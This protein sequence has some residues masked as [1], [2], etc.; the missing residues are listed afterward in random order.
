MAFLT[1]VV[2]FILVVVLCI[3]HSNAQ[4]VPDRCLCPNTSLKAHKWKNIEE[5]SIIE[6]RSRCKAKE[7]ILI[8]KTKDRRCISPN[9]YQA[10]Q[11]QE[12]WNRINKDGKRTTVKMVEC[13]NPRNV[14][15]DMEN[16]T[17]VRQP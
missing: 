16:T 3:Q 13:E 2:S 1:N 9:I 11:L 5:F 8:L 10:V 14:K 6:P 12:C 17:T 7:I 15:K 4:A